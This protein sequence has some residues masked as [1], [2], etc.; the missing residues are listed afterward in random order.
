MTWTDYR[1]PPEWDSFSD[2]E[3]ELIAEAPTHDPDLPDDIARPEAFTT[4]PNERKT[5]T[6]AV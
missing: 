4:Y 2:E 1:H 3:K 6:R 5:F